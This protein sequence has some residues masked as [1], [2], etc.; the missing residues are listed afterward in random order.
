M[1]TYM[2]FIWTVGFRSSRVNKGSKEGT[3]LESI[4]VK[5]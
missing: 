4:E 3:H 5:H 2:A 1:G